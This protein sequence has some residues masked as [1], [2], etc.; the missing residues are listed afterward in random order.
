MKRPDRRPPDLSEANQLD[1][2]LQKLQ[3]E[4]PDAYARAT[5]RLFAKGGAYNPKSKKPR[6]ALT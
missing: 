5:A 4:N 6:Y 1:P 3:R 2:E